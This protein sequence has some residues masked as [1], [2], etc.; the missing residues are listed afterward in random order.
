[1]R[2]LHPGLHRR[3]GRLPRRLAGRARRR[4]PFPRGD[5]PRAVGPPLPL[6]GLRQHLSR[7]RRRL[8]RQVRRRRRTF[9]A[10]RSAAEGD[11]RSGLYRRYSPR[12]PAR[13][14][15]PAL[16]A[17][18]RADRRDR[19][20]ARA[21]H[22]RRRRRRVR[23]RRRPHGPLRRRG[24]RRGRG[25]RSPYGA[26]GAGGDQGRLRDFAERDRAGRRAQSR[27]ADPVP[28]GQGA[29]VQRRRRRRRAGVV[30]RQCPRTDRRILAQ[31]EVGARVDRRRQ[32]GR[33]PAAVRGRR[34]GPASS[35]TRAS[36]RM[37]RSPAST[38]TNSR[39][40]PRPRRWPSSK[41]RSRSRS[42][43]IPQRFGS[44]PSTSAAASAPRPRLASRRSSRSS[45]PKRPRRRSGSPSTGTRNCRW[46]ATGRRQRSR[47]RFCRDA[48]ALSRRSRS[49]PIPTLAS[50]SIRPSR[51][52]GRL[53][54]RAE[55]KELVDHD[56]VSNL[57]PGC[58]FRAPG[59]PQ[60]AFALE[61]AIDE[62]ALRLKTDAIA[63]RKRWDPNPD[64]QRLYD[65]AAGLETWRRRPDA[66]PQR[67]RYLRGVGVAM[68]YWLYLWQLGT[69]VELA[70]EAG[71]L[72]AS[73]ATQDIGT[74]TRSVIADTV[75]REFGARSARGRGSHRRF[76]AAGRADI[77]RQPRDRVDRPAASRRRRQAQGGHCRQDRTQAGAGIERAVAGADRRRARS[78]GRGGASGGQRPD[79]LRQQLAHQG[80]RADR[81]DLR[82]HDAPLVASGDRRRGAELGPGDRGRGR[83][84]SRPCPGARESIP[85]SPSASSPRRHWRAARPREPSFR[86]WATPCTRG[87]RSTPRP[88]TF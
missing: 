22:S 7:R 87:A 69:K 39:Y 82:L 71:R 17:R 45:L 30:V 23:R 11:R 83:H 52:S 41:P 66:E 70:V 27:S 36:S 68:G 28:E 74:G 88:A 1:M 26:G 48:T 20:R 81:L 18:S 44:W 61:Q 85:R 24:G 65:W 42:S 16:A 76:E 55:A 59:G 8:Q 47:S 80:R 79:R 4:D 33:R 73:T 9:A 12:G 19:S 86:D 72:V 14:R 10:R 77:R 32:G 29:E 43:S 46:R 50:P 57:P 21:R 58:A 34:S 64:R 3:G 63:V 25:G 5:R 75:A 56:V 13:R 54:Y 31:E 35:S 62:A 15:G 38:A 67:G 2:V 84:A 40:M 60:L 78:Q 49:R 6:R 51:D 37:R 53:I